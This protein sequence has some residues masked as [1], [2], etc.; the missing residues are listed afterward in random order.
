MPPADLWRV[1]HQHGDR[2]EAHALLRKLA[3]EGVAV[4]EARPARARFLVRVA[5][6][7]QEAAW[8]PPVALGGWGR[9]T[10]IRCRRRVAVV[11][12]AQGGADRRGAVRARLGLPASLARG[13]LNGFRLH[14]DHVMAPCRRRTSISPG[15]SHTNS[16]QRKPA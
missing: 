15:V 6:V 1:A 12:L 10:K 13:S 16:S 2:V 11:V 14:Q 4:V 9:T 8:V 3:A 7:G 5:Q